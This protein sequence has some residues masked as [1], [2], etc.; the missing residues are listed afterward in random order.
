MAEVHPAIDTLHPPP[1]AGSPRPIPSLRGG[2][3]ARDA[4]GVVRGLGAADKHEVWSDELGYD[5]I[6]MRRV[7][8][9]KQVT[10]AYLAGLAR[11][12][13]GRLAWTAPSPPC[14][15]MSRYSSTPATEA[16]RAAAAAA[17]PPGRNVDVNCAW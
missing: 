5:G 15:S 7:V 2:A 16:F 17:S 9:H 1:H 6:D 4:V 14:A 8:G 12:R 10:G 3:T 13:G 11:E